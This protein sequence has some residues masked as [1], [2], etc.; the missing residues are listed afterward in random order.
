TLSKNPTVS[1][2]AHDAQWC[3]A[4]HEVRFNSEISTSGG[5]GGTYTTS[6]NFGDG[7]T[8]SAENPN[9]TYSQ[10]G[11]YD[12]SLTVADS[13]GCSTTV[14]EEEMVVIG[15]L[16]P[17]CNVPEQVCLNQNS[18]FSSNADGE[19]TWNFGDGTTEQSGATVYHTY[20][21][22]G[23]YTVTFTV[24]PNGPCRRTLTFH[25]EVVRVEASFVTS[26]TNLFSCSY[27]FDVQFTST[28]VGDNLTYYYSFGDSRIETD[29]NV[30]HTYTENGEYTPTLTV[31]SPGGCSSRFTGPTIV[32]REPAVSLSLS[33]EGGCIPLLVNL[34][35]GA[36]ASGIVDFLWDYGDGTPTQHTDVPSSE[37][38]YQNVGTYFPSLTVTDTA[39]CSA[40]YSGDSI[41]TGTPILPEQF[42][43]M[44]SLHNFIPKATICASDTV[45][46]YNSMYEDHDTLEY[47]FIIEMNGSPYE[48]KSDETYHDYSFENDTGWA[49]VGLRV[50]YNKCK[51]DTLWWDSVYVAPPIVKIQ[52]SSDCQSPLEYVY[53]MNKNIGAEFWDWIITNE[54]TG[55]TL[56][57]VQ[58]STVDSIEY[59]YPENGRYQCKIIAYNLT[60]GGCE[61]EDKVSSEITAPV[62]EWTIS[63]D[64]I[65]AN[66]RIN[67][68]VSD[69]AA[70]SE[71]A[72]TWGD[73]E[74]PVDIDALEW[75][76]TSA[77]SSI[78]HQYPDSGNYDITIYGR[79]SNGC[80]SVFS[81][82][83][84]VVKAQAS[85]IPAS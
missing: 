69:A 53:R 59:E 13:Y 51:S 42:G 64:T 30:T 44:D 23:Y 85:I 11:T 26:P 54:T 74:D 72:Y 58:H 32:I 27:P 19:C 7:A 47:V 61:Y 62:M 65:C 18:Q 4:P 78:S 50:D 68:N 24:D 10:T 63:R 77:L 38:Y 71:V 17:T 8:S 2:T 22:A 70:F 36:D 21:Q 28:S 5:L 82:H 55:D 79:Q 16:S 33:E 57:Y 1:I 81:R 83:I 40:T 25:T 3:T 52:S 60:M 75:L 6:W 15:M 12:V 80:V 34:S 39:G 41:I 84:Y 9:H 48:E 67:L 66:N 45:V 46:L 56:Q 76:S 43:V 14:L 73:S 20:T 35:D 31:T 37:H 49:Y 29:A